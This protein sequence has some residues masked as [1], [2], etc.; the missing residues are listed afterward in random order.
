MP[1]DEKMLTADELFRY[2]LDNM[3]NLNHPL[4]KL[5]RTVDWPIFGGPVGSFVLSGQRATRPRLADAV[6]GGLGVSQARLRS[7]RCG[8]VGALGGESVLAV[9]LRVGI[10]CARTALRRELLAELL[11]CGLELGQIKPPELASVV[12]DTTVQTKAIRFPT[13][14]R[15]YERSLQHFAK[16]ARDHGIKAHALT[17]SPLTRL[18]VKPKNLASR[19]WAS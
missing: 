14:A 10:F 3:I 11:R 16:R 18:K 9:L 2:R 17:P 8:V 13:D 12:T 7:E 6:D 15:L 19:S 5:A 4:V 1:P